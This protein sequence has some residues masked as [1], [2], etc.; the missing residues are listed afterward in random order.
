MKISFVVFLFLILGL[1]FYIVSNG[2]TKRVD[3]LQEKNT[4]D[5]QETGMANPASKYCADKGGTVKIITDTDGSQFGL[6]TL[7]D[8][9]CE[10][11]AFSRN[12]CDFIGDEAKITEAL[13]AKGLNLSNS[14]VLIRTHFGKY[15]GGSVSPIDGYGGGY[16]FA[17]KE[18]NIVKVLADGNGQIMCSYFKDYPEFPRY[19]VPECLDEVSGKLITR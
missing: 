5:K 11:W 18:G 17:V 14:R 13:K 10:E 2:P 9:A 12:E 16:V 19:L 3:T 1:V 8:K 4:T 6:C 7:G 15:I